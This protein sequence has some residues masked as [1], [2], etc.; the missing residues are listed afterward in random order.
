MGTWSHGPPTYPEN[1]NNLLPSCT[2]N[3]TKFS[4]K[5]LCQSL[6]LNKVAGL[7]CNFIKKETLAQV[8]FCEFREIFQNTVFYKT[9]LLAASEPI[10]VGLLKQSFADVLDNTCS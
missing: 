6:F 4:E 5:H 10:V 8:F 9:T 2:G 7:A 3:F 1:P